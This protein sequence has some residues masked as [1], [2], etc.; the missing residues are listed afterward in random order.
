M[1]VYNRALTKK[2]CGRDPISRGE[3]NGANSL[4][5]RKISEIV[6]LGGNANRCKHTS[7][8]KRFKVLCRNRGD[9]AVVSCAELA[10]FQGA[11]QIL[12]GIKFYGS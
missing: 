1:D 8:D 12:V 6:Q 11:E 2:K 3:I 9:M 10:G 7:I 4:S 5:E